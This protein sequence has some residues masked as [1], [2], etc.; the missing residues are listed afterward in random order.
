M[1]M[2]PEEREGIIGE[3]L[4]ESTEH[5]QLINDKLL[6]AESLVKEGQ[7]VPDADLDAM[8]R[9]A[10]TIKG[11][12]SFMGLTKVVGLTHEAETILQRIKEHK[13]EITLEAIEILFDGFDVLES[14]LN[15]LKDSNQELTD[16]EESVK[17]I[18]ALLEGDAVAPVASSE[19]KGETESTLPP[20]ESTEKQEASQEPLP[21]KSV[22]MPEVSSAKEEET[23]ISEA[24]IKNATYISKS[25]INEKY[26]QQYL[27][28]LE[29]NIEDFNAQLLN[30]EEDN[31]KVDLINNLFRIMHT[32]KGSA[33]IV[34]VL[35]IQSLAHSMENIL[36]VCRE[37]GKTYE[38]MFTLLFMGI[39]VIKELYDSL[40]TTQTVNKDV[41]QL[42]K[43]LEKYYKEIINENS[44]PDKQDVLVKNEEASAA[45]TEP[46]L[47]TDQDI[48]R[49]STTIDISQFSKEERKSAEDLYK[50]GD[51]FY[52]IFI[53]IEGSC[54]TKSMKAFLLEEHLRKLG[55]ILKISPLFESIS[56]EMNSE[57]LIG[58]VYASKEKD[59]KIK[60]SLSVEG[61]N[62]LS[63]D[64]MADEL[65]SSTP[66]KKESDTMIKENSKPVEV[67]AAVQQTDVGKEVAARAKT[68][69][70]EISTIRIDSQKLD[71]LMNLS[72]EL[73]I[74][75][76]QYA[77]LV[78]L[79]NDS[80]T[81][82][83][84]LLRILSDIRTKY[85]TFTGEYKR[86]AS[87]NGNK[88]K[89]DEKMNELME[90]LSS[91]LAYL[92]MTTA[93]SN[94][95]GHI[96][97]LDE[98]TISLGK[99]S[100]DIQTGVMQTRMMPI[101]GVFTR[102][103][104]IVR[105]IAK[106]VE[107]D[108]SLEIEGEDTEL[109][110]KI[111]DSL[112]DPLTHMIRNAVDHGIEDPETR[113]KKGKVRNGTVYLKASHQG[114]NIC[115]EV[116][117]DGKGLDPV[118]I[119][120]SA[121]KKGIIAEDQIDKMT[122]KEKLNLVFMPGFST[123]AQVTG[124]SGRGVGMDVVKSMITSVNGVVD[125]ETEVDKGT[126]F[127]MK[128]PLTLAIIQALLVVVGAETY[129]IPL[130]SVTEIIKTRDEDIYS[131][132]GNDTVKLR[133]HALSLVEL[134]KVIK[135]KGTDRSQQKELK[136][137]VISD[138][139]SQIGVAVDSLIGEE[140]IVIKSLSNHFTE[141]KGVTG[142]SI[143]GD[144]T[145]A[146]I[147]DPVAIIQESR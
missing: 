28:E 49:I 118:A 35:E 40:K 96:H 114:N 119:A 7:K 144:G 126:R 63:F 90:S 56:D 128:I 117:D 44:S 20:V 31:S 127:L 77:R 2:T 24:E 11:T 110:K 123:A 16:I 145:I 140:E 5:L 88:R 84:E 26:L 14:L 134:E 105:D 27:V 136:V 146:L 120:Q 25:N 81:E 6:E 147:L 72:G 133:D 69:S 3:F 75:R 10:H 83:K 47:S 97:T 4:A 51:Q 78:T 103:K 124:L 100:S 53:Q 30:L 38:N 101:E 111:V 139:E 85:E 34:G 39:D 73:V 94:V 32:I 79:F 33:G 95:M 13:M 71:K 108:V 42:C 68:S 57:I 76:A 12:A 41:T 21:A 54:P 37:K 80:L 55:T 87:R 15:D 22:E 70:V 59:D 93:K 58:I 125:I 121:L 122:E 18:K 130:E 112:G 74:V 29:Q 142:A 82:Q 66:E 23:N 65:F 19:T 1:N 46:G 129:A 115:I 116:G 107:K 98:T 138:G 61:V 50:E 132:D 17:R 109:D 8:F 52:Q 67:G 60:S 104:R 36:G 106:Q 91:R 9:S 43:E 86:I 48:K 141:V 137:V 135:I 45:M 92:E 102:F 131:I 113:V 143:L 89:Q 64:L 62:L 99:L